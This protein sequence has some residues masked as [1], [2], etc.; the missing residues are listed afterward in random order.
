MKKLVAY[1]SA[2]G[3]TQTLAENL[4]KAIGANPICIIVPCHRVVG[5]TGKLVGYGGGIE[6]KKQLLLLE[7]TENVKF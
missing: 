6:N 3:T 5:K 1:F 2:T 4:A 7:K